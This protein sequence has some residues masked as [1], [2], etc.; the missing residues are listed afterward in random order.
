MNRR[1]FLGKLLVGAAAF[2]IL[3]SATTY[4]RSWKPLGSGI[5]V[6]NPEWVNA[7][8]EIRFMWNPAVYDA[9]FLEG[10]QTAPIARY[11]R[12]EGDS[13]ELVPEFVTI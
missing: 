13:L 6:P 8:F 5:L 12:T 7:P 9:K 10:Y 2:A 1:N 4:A 3:P 11:K